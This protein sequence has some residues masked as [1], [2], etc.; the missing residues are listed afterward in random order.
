MGNSNSTNSVLSLQH[1]G[2]IIGSIFRKM[3]PGN[4]FR[5]PSSIGPL[6][7]QIKI[8]RFGGMCSLAIVPIN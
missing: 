8:E 3:L 6:Y 7:R 5:T 1:I 4:K 2:P